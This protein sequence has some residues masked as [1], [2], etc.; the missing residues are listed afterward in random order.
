M[1]D[2]DTALQRIDFDCPSAALVIREH[3]EALQKDR[4]EWKARE[5]FAVSDLQRELRVRDA[6]IKLLEGGNV[7]LQGE[8]ERLNIAVD[9]AE[10]ERDALRETVQAMGKEIAQLKMYA[11]TAESIANRSKEHTGH[12]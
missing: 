11:L 8:C 2:L 12:D 3:L 1:T 9:E 6:R 7:M 5:S 10:R 4:D